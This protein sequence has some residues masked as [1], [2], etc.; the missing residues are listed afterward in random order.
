MSRPPARNPG[1]RKRPTPET[2]AAIVADYAAGM[3]TPAVAK[4]WGVGTA[5]AHR[6]VKAAGVNRSRTNAAANAARALEVELAYSGGWYVRGGVRYP[7]FPEQR[8]A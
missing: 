8:S 2:I 6:F 1:S 3:S 5:S 4:K 7:L